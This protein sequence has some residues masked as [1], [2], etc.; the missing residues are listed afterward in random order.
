[1]DPLMSMSQLSVQTFEIGLKA[2]SAVLDKAQAFADA[3]KIR[4]FG[5]A[6]LAFGTR[7]VSARSADSDRR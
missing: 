5:F 2:L 7:H 6:V 3:K 1:M 4:S